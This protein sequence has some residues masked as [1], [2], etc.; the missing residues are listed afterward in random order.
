V[1]PDH[2]GPSALPGA[3]EEVRPEHV[4]RERGILKTRFQ[5]WRRHHPAAASTSA[6]EN[7]PARMISALEHSAMLEQVSGTGPPSRPRESPVMILLYHRIAALSPD[8]SRLC[9]GPDDF[10]VHM[11]A[12]ARQWE[13]VS[14]DVIADGV[15]HD[16]LPAGAAAVTLDDG[17][18]DAMTASEILLDLG[19][20]VTF[21]VT[22]G[23]G[24]LIH[25]T[26]ARVMLGLDQIPD[27]LD[28]TSF[29]PGL[30]I[31][32]TDRAAAFHAV[33]E[34]VWR[35]NADDR[36]RLVDRLAMW[37]DCDLPVRE[38]HRLLTPMEIRD[39]ASR[40]GH[41]IGA[42]TVNHLLLTAH[43]RSTRHEVVENIEYLRWV[44]NRPVRHVAYPYGGFDT[45]VVAACRSLSVE[46][47]VTTASRFVT[48]WDDPLAL[49]RFEVVA[50]NP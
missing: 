48:P 28:L 29:S 15:A 37:S 31:D 43:P 33:N 30:I 10:R 23:G 4:D 32:T 13:P 3:N 49:P 5:R 11:Q 8:P 41:L 19:I 7:D 1:S 12:L 22:S 16:G 20:P 42:H 40:P 44:T 6:D 39:L 21:F 50:R 24:E 26:I 34:I 36:L 18:A 14:L 2:G 17:Y 25:D 45:G 38:S 47:A 46:A 9:V 35:L 27:R